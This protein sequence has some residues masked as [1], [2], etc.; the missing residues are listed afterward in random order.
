MRMLFLA[1]SLAAAVVL[2][3]AARADQIDRTL[4]RNADEITKAVHSLGGH[5]VAVL[6]FDVT[7]GGKPSD[8]Q[9]G[10]ANGKLAQKI[11]N[12]LILTN[13]PNKPLFVLADAG[14]AA[15]KLPA[16][17]T[18]R[19]AVGRT[20]LAGLKDLPLAWDDSQKLA[21]DAFITGELQIEADYKSA[22]IV[23]YGFTT[24]KPDELRTL[25]TTPKPGT[26]P[27]KPG[28]VTDR[29]FLALAG[30]SYALGNVPKS[31]GDG[32]KSAL[33]QVVAKTGFAETASQSPIKLEM[34]VNGVAVVPQTDSAYAGSGRIQPLSLPDP[35]KGSEVYFRLENPSK[36][37]T[38]AVLLAV[39]GRN[40]NWL[41]KD[42]LDSKDP[43][44]QRLWV[45]GPGDKVK[46]QG[47]YENAAGKYA[48]FKVIGDEKSQLEYAMMS[49]DLR[50][51][52]TLHV[53]G[54]RTEPAPKVNDGGLPKTTGDADPATPIKEDVEL[55][56]LSLGV[57]GT[58]SKDVRT[59][60]SLD[61][62]KKRMEE[63][64]GVRT[65][66]NGTLNADPVKVSK[67]EK[68]LIVESETRQT[69]GPIQVVKFKMDP[70]CVAFLQLRYYAPT[71]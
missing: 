29:G 11:E 68:G 16:T 36:D 37:K 67:T 23:L 6:K 58:A 50:G 22:K 40:T 55:S 60:G 69:D 26:D 49:G 25:Y 47:Y 65:A 52:I 30:V 53:F 5:R 62:A 71:R 48:P 45:L 13:D 46:I 15:G 10:L 17:T 4:V 51:L 21:P 12:L 56:V 54:E 35:S 44:D 2:V 9:A 59:A 61:K 1:A 24:A 7:V 19:D 64:A 63:L 3:P 20:A 70:N 34:V 66:P 38:Y 41:S 32:D 33:S 43:K 14:L 42:H 57:G 39:N 31:R 28:V 18:W 27:A 8:F